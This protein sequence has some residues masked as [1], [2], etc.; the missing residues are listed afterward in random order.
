[1]S[2]KLK[3]LVR[4]EEHTSE[5]CSFALHPN[6]LKFQIARGT[7]PLPHTLGETK[8]GTT[9]RCRLHDQ[10]CEEC[11]F[12][13][14]D[15]D[16]ADKKIKSWRETVPHCCFACHDIENYD[17]N[18]EA[19]VKTTDQEIKSIGANSESQIIRELPTERVGFL[20]RTFQIHF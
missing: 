14:V 13:V 17:Q 16:T 15:A 9:L 18:A 8:Y 11:W 12:L 5:V 7:S 10:V 2:R 4:Q 20:H 19:I 6:C 1:M 3:T